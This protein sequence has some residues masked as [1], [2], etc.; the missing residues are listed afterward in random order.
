[1]IE[2]LQT[3]VEEKTKLGFWEKVWKKR[4][5]QKPNVVA[6][7]FLNENGTAEPMEVK[8]EKGFFNIKGKS[9]HERNDCTF[10]MAKERYPLAIIRQWSITPEGTKKW[11]EKEIQEKFCIFQDHAIK[12]IRNAERVRLGERGEGI[13]LNGKAIVGLIIAGIIAIGFLVSFSS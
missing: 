13:K 3:K 2:E 12:G 9:Y 4:R 8:S 10:T 1:M 11:D 6:V 7:L 5:I